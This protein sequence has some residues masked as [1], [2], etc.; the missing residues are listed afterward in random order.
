MNLV[1]ELRL[2]LCKISRERDDYKRKYEELTSKS[3]K[4][5]SRKRL[6]QRGST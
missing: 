2:R 6:W 1:G 5:R 3:S 4:L